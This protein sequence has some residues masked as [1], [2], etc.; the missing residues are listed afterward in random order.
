[1]EISSF[2]PKKSEKKLRK[3][4]K[5]LPEQGAKAERLFGSAGNVKH[6]ERSDGGV[7]VDP[8]VEADDLVNGGVVLGGEL[9]ERVEAGD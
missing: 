3:S 6:T 9:F 8:G 7:A 5:G 2:F 4:L 1:L